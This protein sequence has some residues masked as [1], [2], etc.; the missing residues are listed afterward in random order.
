M[1]HKDWYIETKCDIYNG[2]QPILFS[3]YVILEFP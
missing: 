2:V 1:D 3:C